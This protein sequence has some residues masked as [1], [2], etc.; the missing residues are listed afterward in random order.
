MAKRDPQQDDDRAAR[1]L[2]E[3][4]GAYLALYAFAGSQVT[5]GKL[6]NEQLRSVAGI[7]HLCLVSGGK[8]HKTPGDDHL[9][10]RAD[11]VAKLIA[12]PEMSFELL[13]PAPFD[14]KLARMSLGAVAQILRGWLPEEDLAIS[15]L[16]PRIGRTR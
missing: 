5:L 6:S 8:A 11:V 16:L 15:K 12:N 9:F 7:F 13:A 1:E 14:V 2:N 10:P 4:K 3:V